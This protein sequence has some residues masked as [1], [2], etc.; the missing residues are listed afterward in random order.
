MAIFFDGM[1]DKY[2]FGKH[3]T[4]NFERCICYKYYLWKSIEC[5]GKQ[6]F[7]PLNWS[8]KVAF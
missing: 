7:F 4:A 1:N 2:E 3:R 6:K 8:L 5:L